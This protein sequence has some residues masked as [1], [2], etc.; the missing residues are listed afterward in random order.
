MQCW[1]PI[2]NLLRCFWNV[3]M[4]GNYFKPWSWAG[5]VGS[6]FT[7]SARLYTTL[8]AAAVKAR[9]KWY[10]SSCKV[11]EFCLNPLGLVRASQ[12]APVPHRGPEAWARYFIYRVNFLSTGST[13]KSPNP[14]GNF[15]I[16]TLSIKTKEVPIRDM[17]I[18]VQGNTSPKQIKIKVH[19]WPGHATISPNRYSPAQFENRIK[20]RRYMYMYVRRITRS[21]MY[22][23]APFC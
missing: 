16:R 13:K 23:K 22:Q 19:V 3:V 12:W 8:K 17:V 4:D 10:R 6:G 21:T 18:K 14:T 11:F 2:Y 5:A 9:Y 15:L 20:P 7:I 1:V